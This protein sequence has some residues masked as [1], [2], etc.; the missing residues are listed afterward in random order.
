MSRLMDM[1]DL[2]FFLVS[3]CYSLL[4]HWNEPGMPA[5]DYCDVGF[6]GGALAELKRA[7]SR[8]IGMI[9]ATAFNGEHNHCPPPR[10][11]K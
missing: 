6:E 10:R 2:D 7:E 9:A 3:Q 5:T 8:G 11:H 1:I 4:H